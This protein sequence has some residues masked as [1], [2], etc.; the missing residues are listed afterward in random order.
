MIDEKDRQLIYDAVHNRI[1]DARIKI[2]KLAQGKETKEEFAKVVDEIIER[3]QREA[4]DRA[5]VQANQA[6]SVRRLENQV[7]NLRAALSKYAEC[8]HGV[9]DD[10]CTKEARAALYPFVADELA[11]VAP[12]K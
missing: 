12:K 7:Q 4:A 8:R 5:I 2:S 3:A 6:A 11:A 1:M 9:V 10:N